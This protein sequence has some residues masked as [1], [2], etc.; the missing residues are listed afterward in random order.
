MYIRWIERKTHGNATSPS[1][2]SS[3]AEEGEDGI[4]DASGVVELQGRA[5]LAEDILMRVFLRNLAADR[6][7]KRKSGEESD[8]H[9]GRLDEDHGENDTC[10]DLTGGV[11]L[12]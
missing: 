7:G 3:I 11:V 9:E 5:D 4:C 8:K 2:R 6:G 10:G 1:L 12:R